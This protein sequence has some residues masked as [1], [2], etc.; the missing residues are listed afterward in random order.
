MPR[1]LRTDKKEIQKLDKVYL[2]NIHSE[3][4]LRDLVGVI[5]RMREVSC[6][7]LG[8]PCDCKYGM[9][10]DTPADHL[11]PYGETTGCCELAEAAQILARMTEG[12]RQ[13]ILTRPLKMSKKVTRKRCSKKHYVAQVSVKK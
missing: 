6:C 5:M 7:Y 10:R 12:E 1:T 11:R 13:E 3:K 9:E 4:S 2:N 8:P